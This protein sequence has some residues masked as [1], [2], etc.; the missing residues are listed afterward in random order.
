MYLV[1]KAEGLVGTIDH[2]GILTSLEVA[3]LYRNTD[4]F[5]D[6]SDFQAMGLTTI[7]AMA[8][9]VIPIATSPGGVSELFEHEVSGFYFPNEN[10]SERIF[11]VLSDFV[12][13]PPS[14]DEISRNSIVNTEKFVPEYSALNL[15]RALGR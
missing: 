14:F 8:S 15:V 5:L 10:S 13:N 9:G 7:E 1:T 2:R 3:E 11:G 12:K 4:F 6:L